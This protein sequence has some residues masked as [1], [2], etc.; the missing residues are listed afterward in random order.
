[1]SM[2]GIYDVRVSV[3]F[4]A[5]FSMCSLLTKGFQAEGLILLLWF[6]NKKYIECFFYFFLPKTMKQVFCEKITQLRNCSK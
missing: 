5:W 1:M 6:P 2:G 3:G 4:I